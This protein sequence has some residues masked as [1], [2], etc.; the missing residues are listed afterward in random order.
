MQTIFKNYIGFIIGL[1]FGSI[2]STTVS[3]S[4][5]YNSEAVGDILSIQECLLKL[6]KGE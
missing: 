2:V 3:Y 6:N 4:L 5:F 1:I